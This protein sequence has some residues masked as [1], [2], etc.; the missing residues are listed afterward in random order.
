MDGSTV[1]TRSL[2]SLAQSPSTL[3]PPNIYQRKHVIAELQQELEQITAKNN[4][5][6]T[7]IASAQKGREES[8]KYSIPLLSHSYNDTNWRVRLFAFHSF[9]FGLVRTIERKN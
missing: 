9:L 1:F 5:M 2:R 7:Q 4:E 6:E 8:V 3:F